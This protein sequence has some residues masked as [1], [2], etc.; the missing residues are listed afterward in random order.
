MRQRGDFKKPKSVAHESEST[1]KAT[2]HR[3]RCESECGDPICSHGGK[4]SNQRGSKNSEK[5]IMSPAYRYKRTIYGSDIRLE[6]PSIHCLG[7]CCRFGRHLVHLNFVKRS[8][9]S[10]TRLLHTHQDLDDEALVRLACSIKSDTPVVSCNC[11][12]PWRKL[13]SLWVIV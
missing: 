11:T 2:P 4:V 9:S 8:N 5:L 6:P 7:F 3:P 13:L 1:Y 10:S 12:L